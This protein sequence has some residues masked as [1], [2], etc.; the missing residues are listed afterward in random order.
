MNN[1]QA[2]RADPSSERLN[3]SGGDGAIQISG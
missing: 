3:L 2:K 1:P